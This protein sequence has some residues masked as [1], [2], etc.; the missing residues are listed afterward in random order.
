MKLYSID[1]GIEELI[2]VTNDIPVMKKYMYRPRFVGKEDN[3]VAPILGTM[4]D[5][6]FVFY[7]TKHKKLDIHEFSSKIF[8]KIHLGDQSVVR[9]MI[10]D[11]K[12]DFDVR[13]NLIL[14]LNSGGYYIID[15]EKASWNIGLT[16]HA[17]DGVYEG[18]FIETTE[19]NTIIHSYNFENMTF[20]KTHLDIVGAGL[21]IIG[22]LEDGRVLIKYHYYNSQE[23]GIIAT[24]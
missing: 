10:Y 2:T 19:D 1:T 22:V 20:N 23:S 12:T 6:G 16:N 14:D 21:D 7:N 18:V 8:S 5:S 3:I 9:V 24:K 4:T 17:Y 15:D 11:E 13:R